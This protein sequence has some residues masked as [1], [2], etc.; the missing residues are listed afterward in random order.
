MATAVAV[1]STPTPRSVVLGTV[2]WVAIV[3]LLSASGVFVRLPFPT[4]QLIILALVAFSLIAATRVTSVRRWVETLPWRA[5]VGIHALRLVGAVFL[6]LG[7]RGLLAP[8]FASRAGWG[9]IVAAVGAIALVAFSIAPERMR[10]LHNLWNV[11]GLA[12]LIVAVGT[13]TMV[14]AQGQIPGMDPLL[15]LPLS[16]VPLFFVPILLTGHIVLLRRVNARRA[17]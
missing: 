1:S 9:D 5:L 3:I 8:A 6:L 15:R 11:F 10:W 14:A 12:D 2:L 7:A 13:A 17:A 16:F 4:A